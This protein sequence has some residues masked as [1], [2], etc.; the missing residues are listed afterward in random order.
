MAA[1][2]GSRT[3]GWIHWRQLNE[4]MSMKIFGK[5]ITDLSPKKLRTCKMLQHSIE[6]EFEVI[7]ELSRKKVQ[8]YKSGREPGVCVGGGL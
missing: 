4:M 5:E 8:R 7:S 1:E 2:G 3:K 6:Q